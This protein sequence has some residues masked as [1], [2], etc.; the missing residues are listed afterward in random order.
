MRM[1]V[2]VVYNKVYFMGL[3]HE[4]L[5]I[6][7]VVLVEKKKKK[8]SVPI[9]AISHDGSSRYEYRV[10]VLS[11]ISWSSVCG[12]MPAQQGILSLEISLV[13]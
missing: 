1:V 9:C 5:N 11:S 10:K 6:V 3:Y 2:V 13:L 8:R 7:L 12:Y 4:I